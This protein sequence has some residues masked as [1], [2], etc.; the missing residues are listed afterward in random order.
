MR[1]HCCAESWTSHVIRHH[2]ETL[3][4]PLNVR[5]F[6]TVHGCNLHNDELTAVHCS[7]PT[8]TTMVLDTKESAEPLLPAPATHPVQS[9][10]VRPVIITF[11]DDSGEAVGGVAEQR[12]A[13]I[14]EG[15]ETQFGQPKSILSVL[16]QIVIMMVVLFVTGAACMTGLVWL[17]SYFDA[18]DA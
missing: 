9:F 3:T 8:H 16:P 5:S 6:S 1:D 12:R 2:G 4:S 10:R 18:F 7:P 17:L 13:V 15:A 14:L 11:L